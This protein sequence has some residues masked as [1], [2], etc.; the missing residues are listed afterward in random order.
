MNATTAALIVICLML[1]TNVV[2][3]DDI[4]KNSAAWNTLAWFATLVALADGLTRVGF[5]KWFAEA[6]A[7]HMSGFTPNEAILVLLRDQFF[8]SLHVCQ[9]YRA[10]YGA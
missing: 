3:W 6:V 10:C 8:R 5:V 9:R 4:T 1:V 2:T 7:T